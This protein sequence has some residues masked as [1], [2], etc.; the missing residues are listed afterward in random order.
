[1]KLPPAP[2]RVG[3]VREAVEAGLANYGTYT[4]L[5]D[6][7]GVTRA[8]IN[9]WCSGD[10]ENLRWEHL[11]SLCEIA[12]MSVAYVAMGYGPRGP[13]RAEADLLEL[14]GILNN[15]PPDDRQKLA[16]EVLA[17]ARFRA[18]NAT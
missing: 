17:F 11:F 6:A 5:A 7:I 15:L 3:R 4:A 14:T 16:A 12:D 2:G 10:S 9:Q 1:M 13:Y 8:A 18:A